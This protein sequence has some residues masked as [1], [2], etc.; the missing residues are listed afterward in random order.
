M[1]WEKA[2]RVLRGLV[3]KVRDPRDAQ[4]LRMAKRFL[5]E[6]GISSIMAAKLERG[7]RSDNAVMEH[8]AVAI[9]KS[10]ALADLADVAKRHPGTEIATECQIAMSALQHDVEEE[11][12]AAMKIPILAGR[13]SPR[14]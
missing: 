3:I 10:A 1:R 14:R 8:E 7:H 2:V 6:A 13:S 12:R 5:E 4:T 9:K 11:E